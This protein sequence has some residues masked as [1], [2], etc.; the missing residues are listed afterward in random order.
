[1]RI[2]D[3][4]EM[5]TTSSSPRCSLSRCRRAACCKTL[6]AHAG[7]ERREGHPGADRDL[8]ILLRTGSPKFAWVNRP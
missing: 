2:Y 8:Y 4:Q 1:M 3:F 5:R 6:R 7:S